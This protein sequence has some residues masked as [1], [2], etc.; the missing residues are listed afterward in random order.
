L[1][2]EATEKAWRFE[3]V[4][5]STTLDRQREKVTEGA[6]REVAR[7]G[8]VDLVAAHHQRGQVVGRI[9]AC[10]VEGGLLRVRGRLDRAAPG[11]EQLRERLERGEQL[12]LSLGGKVRQAHWGYDADTEGPV[13]H[14]DEVTVEHVAVCRAQEAVN[15]DVRVRLVEGEE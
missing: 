7:T 3:G 5:S 12:G 2:D 1:A 10:E 11:A 13:R 8:P 15:P 9:E 4:A 14:L 6:L